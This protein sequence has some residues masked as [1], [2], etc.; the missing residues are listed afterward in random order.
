MR[1]ESASAVSLIRKFVFFDPFFWLLEQPK[2]YCF[3]SVVKLLFDRA[4]L[5]FVRNAL[6]LLG[7]TSVARTK[8]QTICWKLGS[9]KRLSSNRLYWQRKLTFGRSRR[10]QEVR[11]MTG[12]HAHHARARNFAD[13]N[14]FPGVS[15][16]KRFLAA[17]N[18]IY[19]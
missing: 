12:T 9:I 13:S 11:A 8:N 10:R 6:L 5:S 3:F 4:K 2:L 17:E 18:H 1:C 16:K 15:G 7:D 19:A 14:F